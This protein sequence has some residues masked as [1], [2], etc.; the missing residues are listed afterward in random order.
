MM[1][2]I[3]Q[4]QRGQID[5]AIKD[6]QRVDSNR[7]W[8]PARAAIALLNGERKRVIE[9]LSRRGDVSAIDRMKLLALIPTE[10]PMQT[11]LLAIATE[12]LSPPGDVHHDRWLGH[13]QL[14]AGKFDEAVA[15]LEVH[16]NSVLVWPI[17]S[18]AYHQLGKTR[19]A[20]RYLD[21]SSIWLGLTNRMS[22]A[23][24]A[25]AM[26]RPGNDPIAWLLQ[27]VAHREAKQ[28]ID[29]P[30]AL[31]AE[32][33]RL[34]AEQDELRLDRAARAEA[35]FQRLID[36]AGNDPAPWFRRARWYTDRGEPEKALADCTKAIELTP[37]DAHVYVTRANLLLQFDRVEQ[38][39]VDFD[40][41]LA[42]A[43]DDAGV[44]KA[45]GYVYENLGQWDEALADYQKAIDLAPED[46]PSWKT[47][48][49]NFAQSQQ[50]DR[51][52]ALYTSLIEHH[53]DNAELW[54][55]RAAAYFQL[56]QWDQAIE[57]Y[58]EVIK[59]N[60]KDASVWK[61]RALAN[62]AVGNY[63]RAIADSDEAIRLDPAFPWSY[64]QR[65]EAHLA[66]GNHAQAI[67]DCNELI[68]MKPSDSWAYWIR[69]KAFL[70]TNNP[71]QA[72]VDC[73]E[74][75]RLQASRQAAYVHR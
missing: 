19:L 25:D 16:R 75:I 2:M 39:W 56:Q 64:G 15:T 53:S 62:K 61:D 54:Q 30:E 37:D 29:G 33:E 50:W 36:S 74:A 72:I 65:A 42:L 55:A 20:H 7:F 52:I 60:P 44:W 69:G 48:A 24:F 59:L 70:N 31:A 63:E 57:S 49:D 34:V 17:L 47:R 26:S 45:R 3:L 43:P 73:T 35:G 58:S 14:R 71:D 66:M 10:G 4:V 6:A 11:E 12:N 41:A 18:M 28:L 21:L 51:A 38:A 9:Y 40:T 27:V 22:P 67:A 1:H 8:V 13:A 32:E 23:Q 68:Q 46:W 5:V